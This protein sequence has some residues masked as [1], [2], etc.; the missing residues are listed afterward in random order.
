M[1]RNKEQVRV[2]YHMKEE[3]KLPWLSLDHS[4]MWTLLLNNNLN[5]TCLSLYVWISKQGSILI[6]TF[7]CQKH[8]AILT[9][10]YV[11][12]SHRHRGW[13]F[14]WH[15]IKYCPCLSRQTPISRSNTLKYFVFTRLVRINFINCNYFMNQWWICQTLLFTGYS[16]SIL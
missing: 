4:F 6:C 8:A 3:K 2:I 10:A 5:V 13:F 9:G 14:S 15:N 12:G 16:G 11:A 1:Q 7:A